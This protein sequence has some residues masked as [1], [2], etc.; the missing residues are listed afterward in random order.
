MG[1][2]YLT[3]AGLAPSDDA[4]NV[5]RI[6]V[7]AAA[8]A[9][10]LLVANLIKGLGRFAR[11]NSILQSIPAAP[12]SNFIL[13]H[14]FPLLKAPKE[15]RGAWDLMEDWS[16]SANRGLVRF[17]VLGTN[18]VIVND[19]ILFKRIF[20]TRFK[21]YGKD[22]TLSY[23][24]FMPILGTGLVTADG[25]LWQKQ[26]LLMGPA[27]RVDILDDIVDIAQRGAT[28]LADK[29]EQYKGTGQIVHLEEEFRLMT[30]Q[31]IGEAILSL[32]P[33]E[34]DRVS[35][36]HHHVILDSVPSSMECIG[37]PATDR[38]TNHQH[39]TCP[40]LVIG[41][42]SLFSSML[43]LSTA[44]HCEPESFILCCLFTPFV[45]QQVFPQLY[46]PV[47]EEGNQRVL[48][49]Y[50]KYLPTPSWFSFKHKMSQLNSY[51]VNLIR[52]R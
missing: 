20:Q 30:L 52:S 18:G 6:L 49:P 24:P 31:I 12:G 19:P 42:E 5:I 27:L 35:H 9:L 10:T 11:N 23:H 37:W 7:L 3:M 8:L 40:L 50:R 46:L 34:C 36:S 47:M 1:N 17:R 41:N 33:E 25:D 44:A 43:H 4:A 38:R 14:V 28:R 26:R 48:R 15:G 51:L 16:K 21:I 29:L 2:K 13:G 39:P 45:L 22:L 32:P